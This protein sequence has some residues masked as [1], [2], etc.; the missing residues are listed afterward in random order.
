MGQAEQISGQIITGNFA[1]TSGMML[2]RSAPD[3]PK[4]WK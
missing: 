2:K 1:A 3:P 4:I